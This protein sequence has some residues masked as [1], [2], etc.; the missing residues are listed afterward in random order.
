MA[1]IVDCTGEHGSGYLE[2]NESRSR[3]DVC[4]CLA[5][6]RNKQYGDL[7]NTEPKKQDL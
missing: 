4:S 2:E 6:K 3:V 1:R 5:L 7:Q